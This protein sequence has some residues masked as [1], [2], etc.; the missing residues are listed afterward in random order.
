MLVVG[1]NWLGDAIMSL[2]AMA[3]LRARQP[4]AFIT[5]LVRPALAEL[6]ALCPYVDEV[7]VQD[8]GFFGTFRTAAAVRRGGYATAWVMPK[9]FRSALLAR[10]GG[11]PERVGLPGHG[12]DWLLTRVVALSE[13]G[14]RHQVFEYL[15]LVGAQPAEAVQPPYLRPP[16]EAVVVVRQ[17][18]AK[19]GA[20]EAPLVGMFPGAAR[21][22]SKRWPAERFAAVARRLVIE[23]GCRVA[24]FGSEADREDCE[25]V[26]VAAGVGVMNLAG[27]TRLDA[28]A[29]WLSLCRVAIA[30]DSGG[31]HL[32]A[33]LGVPTVGIF[34]ITDPTRTGPVGQ[35]HRLVTADGVNRSRAVPR[36]SAVARTA[37]LSI[38]PSRVYSA[39]Q[40]LLA[41]AAG[42]ST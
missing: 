19:W 15:D 1:L 25:A 2:S 20:P 6:W 12:R 7:A 13:G 26:T 32:A 27:T 3:V 28:L 5:I 34:G 37:M 9:S 21:G 8:M 42:G 35:G 23:D 22:P 17:R 18:L 41:K 4:G 24:V 30:N 11:A 29:A 14:S 10:W 16:A 40:E 33:G 31:M 36:D 39:A 38:E